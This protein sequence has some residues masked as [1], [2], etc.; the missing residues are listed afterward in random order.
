MPGA[1]AR[2]TASKV[3]NLTLFFLGILCVPFEPLSISTNVSSGGT[4]QVPALLRWTL[5]V[6]NRHPIVL[7]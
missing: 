7:H 2:F 3:T 1:L 6:C 5:S 4:I